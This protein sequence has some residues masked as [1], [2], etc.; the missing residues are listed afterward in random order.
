MAKI[1]RFY[2][3]HEISRGVANS[4]MFSWAE[5][6]DKNGIPTQFIIFFRNR[7][8]LLEMI[9]DSDAE[10]L[11][12]RIFKTILIRKVIKFSCLFSFGQK[13]SPKSLNHYP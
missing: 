6:L 13:K 4:Q 2:I 10:I 12:F 7:K 1:K 11:I 8:A 3:S 9:R 5:I